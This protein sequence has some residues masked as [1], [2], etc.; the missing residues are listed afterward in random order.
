MRR[1]VLLIVDLMLMLAAT[2]LA[3][4]LRYNFEFSEGRI[5]EHLPYL[6]STAVAALIVFPAAGLNRTVWR[7]SSLPDYL[8][9][10][11]AIAAAIFG[12]VA[13]AFAYNRLEGVAR[14]LPFLQLLAATAFLIGARVLHKLIHLARHQRKA[15]AA[16][17]DMTHEA[18]ALTVLIAG[19]SRLTEVYIQAAAELFPGKIKIAGLLGRSDRQ[20]GRLIAAHP[21]LGVPEDIEAVL[22]SLEV[23]G[24]SVDR[25]VVASAFGELSPEVRD[26]LLCVERSRSITLQ[27]LAEDL[28]F[29][30]GGRDPSGGEGKP[31]PPRSVPSEL[32]FEIAPAELEMLAQRKYWMI[33]RAMD[34]LAAFTLLVLC[35]PV[36]LIAA[37]LVAASLGF[38]VVFWQQRP[39]LSGR[40]F[41]LYKLRTMNSAHAPDGRR[42]SDLERTSIVGNTLRR[43]RVDELPQL[44]NILR[45]DMSFTGPRPLLPRDQSEAYRARLLVRPGLTGWAQVVGGRAISPED[46][47]ALDVWYVRNASLALDVEIAVRTVPV[48]L[49]GER[50]SVSLIERAWSDLS[51]SGVLKG[52]VAH[53]RK[54]DLCCVSARV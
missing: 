18:P 9:V 36:M 11:A 43:L 46:K 21:I 7:F 40:P 1:S 28:G 25:I 22:D 5:L 15:S 29:D 37:A 53:K 49:F 10:T 41:R 30:S 39:G 19:V 31:K 27:F 35:T 8:R 14:S 44:F 50:I 51:E 52:E 42:L 4:V 24:I 6:A 48:V 38:P 13:V 26:A 3:N 33:K 16:F 34:A 23:H 17:L 47:A 2:F 54:N 20:V 32:R 45:G 12:A